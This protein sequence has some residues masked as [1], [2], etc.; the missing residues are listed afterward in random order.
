[1]PSSRIYRPQSFRI[2]RANRRVATKS[3]LTSGILH[4]YLV[5][6]RG[7]S[8][9]LFLSNALMRR[10]GMFGIHLA[11]VCETCVDTPFKW[12]ARLVKDNA[13]RAKIKYRCTCGE[14][15]VTRFKYNFIVESCPG[16]GIILQVDRVINQENSDFHV[17]VAFGFNWIRLDRTRKA[18]RVA[19]RTSRVSISFDCESSVS[20]DEISREASPE[21][22]AIERRSSRL[23]NNPGG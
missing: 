10:R 1:M 11:I 7:T 17:I 2:P 19:L 5:R 16:L 9:P 21:K 15:R 22:W 13:Y 14:L 20:I 23:K 12:H 6:T 3:P 18:K 8:P 4:K